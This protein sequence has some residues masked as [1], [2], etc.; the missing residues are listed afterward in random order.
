MTN[1]RPL[2]QLVDASLIEALLQRMEPAQLRLE[3]P[4]PGSSLRTGAGHCASQCDTPVR[5]GRESIFRRNSGK[6][7]EQRVRSVPFD[8]PL[9][10]PCEQCSA[11]A[12]RS[13]FPDA[14][15]PPC[16]SGRLPKTETDTAGS[17]PGR[18][19]N[20]GVLR[21]MEQV[22]RGD[23]AG[24]PL[25]RLRRP[26]TNWLARHRNI[27]RRETERAS[28]VAAS[29]ERDSSTPAPVPGSP[30]NLK[31]TLCSPTLGGPQAEPALLQLA[32]S[33]PA[34]RSCDERRNCPSTSRI[35]T[36]PRAP[37]AAPP[38]P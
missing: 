8:E 32:P 15:A 22:A 27:A 3:S 13:V 11:R 19:L 24:P 7:V 25:P 29:I 23:A 20:G 18:G 36:R 6:F 28:S 16:G 17:F 10:G 31:G 33:H 5:P 30:P 26:G 2:L 21:S 34:Q 37:T 12:D 9:P 1:P 38:T 35:Q 14:V 4:R